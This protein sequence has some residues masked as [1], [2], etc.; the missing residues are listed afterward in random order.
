MK[1]TSKNITFLLLLLAPFYSISQDYNFLKKNGEYFFGKPN[2]YNK[3]KVISGYRIDSTTLKESMKFYHD[4]LSFA[5]TYDTTGCPYYFSYP[6]LDLTG[7]SWLGK[8]LMTTPSGNFISL[9]QNADSIFIKTKAQVGDTFLVFSSYSNGN[10]VK[11]T[12]ENHDTLTFLGITDSVKTILLLEEDTAGNPVKTSPIHGKRFKVSRLYGIVQTL[13][14]LEF[15]ND[16]SEYSIAGIPSPQK[17]FHLLTKGEVYNYSVGDEWIKVRIYPNLKRVYWY[18][19]VLKKYFSA[20][21]DTVYYEIYRKSEK[22]TL[23]AGS[24]LQVSNISK[25]VY[26]DYYT[27]LN[28]LVTSQLPE[29]SK[30]LSNYKLHRSSMYI[31]SCGGYQ[32]QNITV[33]IEEGWR[34]CQNDSTKLTIFESDGGDISYL[35]GLGTLSSYYYNTYGGDSYYENLVFFKKGTDTC[36][37]H[38]MPDAIQENSIEEIA[39]EIYPNP[40]SKQVIIS[41]ISDSPDGIN[42]SM[43]DGMGKKVSQF[44]IRDGFKTLSLDHLSNGIYYFQ[45]H[46]EE[47]TIS[48]KKLIVQH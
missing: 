30:P 23:I 36:G 13:S 45:F 46:T 25:G 41:A 17:G 7:P 42:G 14:L 8:E 3:N 27:G 24:G 22:V 11:G 4:Q 26:T 12:I 15:P 6:L 44:V 31:R 21:G 2:S 48:R 43:Y 37:T 34:S 32:Y 10:I 33:G 40:A 39:V 38:S 9:N 20:N 29:E 28:Q 18:C 1:N 47:G 35:E 16:S 5:E 19:N